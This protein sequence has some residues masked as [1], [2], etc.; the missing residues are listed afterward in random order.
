MRAWAIVAGLAAGFGDL[1]A[2]QE[3]EIQAELL[4]PLATQ[5]SHKDDR[6]SARVASPDALKGDTLEGKVTD[7]RAGSRLR[8]SSTLTFAFDTLRHGGTA[9]PIT[10]QRMHIGTI[11]ITDNGITQLSY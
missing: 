2:A 11:R 10:A 1:A 8:G 4:S 7:V 5:T 6:V 3:M 9:M